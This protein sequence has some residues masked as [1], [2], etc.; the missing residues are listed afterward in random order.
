[1]NAFRPFY[2]YVLKPIFIVAHS[3]NVQGSGKSNPFCYYN[4]SS[5]CLVLLCKYTCHLLSLYMTEAAAQRCSL[6]EV[7]LEISQNS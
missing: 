2:H 7:F 4:A 3:L 6:E 1:M 5:V